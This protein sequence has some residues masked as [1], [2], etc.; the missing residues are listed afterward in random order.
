MTHALLGRAAAVVI[1]ATAP[2]CTRATAP[3]SS[4]ATSV[5]GGSARASSP[6]E[7][8]AERRACQPK[9]F[10]MIHQVAAGFQGKTY[11]MAGYL[12]GRSDGVFLVSGSGPSGPRLFEVTK[13]GSRIRSVTHVAQA[14]GKLDPE[15]MARVID[16]VY[17]AECPQGSGV[18]TADRYL[19]R[20]AVESLDG[21]VDSME[22]ELDRRTL[23]VIAKRFDRAG[24][25]QASA[26]FEG[27]RDSADLPVASRIRFEHRNGFSLDIA[28]IEYRAPF[29]F[30]DDLLELTADGETPP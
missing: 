3:F 19:Y 4:T 21:D 23:A 17:F 11:V 24:E 25:R 27:Y 7:A 15:R 16:L 9:R 26:R 29:E 30:G 22:M 20:C 2:A 18:A 6:D 8:L 10:K 28:L 5:C 14:R 13:N 12:L 1:A